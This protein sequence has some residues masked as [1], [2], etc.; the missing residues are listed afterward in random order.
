MQTKQADKQTDLDDLPQD[1]R[2]PRTAKP[3]TATEEVLRLLH[4]GADG[5]LI[6]QQLRIPPSRLRRIL[7]SPTLQKAVEE[8]RQVAR[9]ERI[10]GS[11]GGDSGPLKALLSGGRGGLTPA[12][13]GTQRDSEG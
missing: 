8:D 6:R 13:R 9:I 2:T 10:V 3:R 12:Y 7:N 1:P 4:A 11:R 5:G